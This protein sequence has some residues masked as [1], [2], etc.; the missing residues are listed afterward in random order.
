[1]KTLGTVSLLIPLGNGSP[2]GAEEDGMPIERRIYQVGHDRFG[3]FH[4]DYH[5]HV[6]NIH[7]E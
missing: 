3:T 7:F 2:L 5:N 6:A 4:T 1:V